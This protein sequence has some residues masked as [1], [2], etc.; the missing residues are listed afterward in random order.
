M[1]SKH[2]AVITVLYFYRTG[3]ALIVM[4]DVIQRKVGKMQNFT[5]LLW[6]SS[7]NEG[8]VVDP[9]FDAS[10]VLSEALKDNIR[11]RYVLLTH[12][13][14]DHVQDAERLSSITSSRIV[15]HS[16]S[17]VRKDMPVEDGSRLELGNSFIEV[18]HTPGHT[19]DSCCYLAGGRLFTG[20]TLFVGECGRVDLEDSDPESMFT[21]LLV[22]LRSLPDGTVVY[23]GH[24]Y[25]K[26]PFSTIGEEKRSNYTMKE[27][28][29]EEFLSFIT[30]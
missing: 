1:L 7:T 22:R 21:S 12:H 13:H 27:R 24:D 5:Y 2:M 8:A 14:F 18:I 9:S 23:P 10:A 17:P 29:K 28:T 20:D 4:I 15:A 25:G 6:D 16:S 3:V 26:T 11:I 19:A 30:S